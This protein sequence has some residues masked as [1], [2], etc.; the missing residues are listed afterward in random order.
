MYYAFGKGAALAHS[1]WQRTAR[2]CPSI[3]LKESRLHRHGYEYHGG[4]DDKVSESLQMGSVPRYEIPFRSAD[5][6]F[7]GIR[8]NVVYKNL[9]PTKNLNLRLTVL[10]PSTS[11]DCLTSHFPSPHLP[12]PDERWVPKLASLGNHVPPQLARP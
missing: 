8:L 11:G 5:S 1:C 9:H 4:A 12:Q 10:I 6:H 3:R 7:P 2:W